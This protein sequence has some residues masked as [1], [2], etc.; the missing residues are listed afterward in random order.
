MRELHEKYVK[1]ETKGIYIFV[2]WD[3]INRNAD[4]CIK[5]ETKRG[6]IYKTYKWLDG[7]VETIRYGLDGIVVE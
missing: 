3:D 6:C 7:K 5:T 2:G 4:K 1:V